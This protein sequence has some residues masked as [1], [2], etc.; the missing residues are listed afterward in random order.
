MKF[1]NL[2]IVILCCTQLSCGQTNDKCSKLL[3]E[4]LVLTDISLNDEMSKQIKLFNNCFIDAIDQEIIWSEPIISM[5]LVESLKK[6]ESKNTFQDLLD[7][8]NTLKENPE[9]LEIRNRF[10]LLA[11][12]TDKKLIDKDWEKDKLK[13]KKIGITEKQI[14]EIYEQSLLKGNEELTYKDLLEKVES[15]RNVTIGFNPPSNFE[16]DYDYEKIFTQTDDFNFDEALIE[17][18][19]KKKKLLLYFTGYGCINARRMEDQTLNK[20]EILKIISN[21]YLF[22]PLYVDDQKEITIKGNPK[23]KNIGNK[24]ADLQKTKF[25]NNNQPHF[26][27]LD[28]EGNLIDQIG[29]VDFEKFKIFLDRNKK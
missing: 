8:V 18:K 19:Q 27:I 12:I 1:T 16:Y 20:S 13:F 11:E 26:V 15:N 9:Y 29:F 5:Y 22:F 7:F 17:S 10:E 25:R 3:N 4:E 14:N 23:I 6:G 24:Y 2:L 28:E 21:Q